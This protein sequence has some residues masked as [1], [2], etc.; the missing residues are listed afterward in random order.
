MLTAI[1]KNESKSDRTGFGR[2][3]AFV[4]HVLGLL[5]RPQA[6]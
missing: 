1:I 6:A 5:V 2:V 4:T 3:V